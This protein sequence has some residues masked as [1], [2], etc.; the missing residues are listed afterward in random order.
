MVRSYERVRLLN[1]EVDNLTMDELVGGFRDLKEGGE[2]EWP[3]Q[4]GSLARERSTPSRGRA[5]FFLPDARARARPEVGAD[6]GT[7]GPEVDNL[8]RPWRVRQS[9]DGE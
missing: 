6:S 3:D 2:H 9:E 8:R 5:G 4:G 1:V 7:G